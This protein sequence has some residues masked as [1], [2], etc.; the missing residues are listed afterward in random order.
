M[1]LREYLDDLQIPVRKFA[2]KVGVSYPMIYKIM[3]GGDMRLSLALA[4]EA[5]TK[6]IV[7][8]Q[9]LKPTQQIPAKKNQVE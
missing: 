3:K 1:N 5:A 4:I 8:A 2:R 9:A 7:T 6:G